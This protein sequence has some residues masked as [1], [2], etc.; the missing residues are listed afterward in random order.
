[1]HEVAENDGDQQ[2]AFRGLNTSVVALG[3]ES[4]GPDLSPKWLFHI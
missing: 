1:M 2:A 4:G 3:D